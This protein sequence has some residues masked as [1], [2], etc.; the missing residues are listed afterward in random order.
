MAKG[1][2]SSIEKN[3]FNVSMKAVNKR[4]PAD[5][6]FLDFQEILNR[7]CAGK[8]TVL[9]QVMTK[10]RANVMDQD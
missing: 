4:E 5:K 9:H 10:W 1:G 8:K 2:F 3:N 6:F 7:S